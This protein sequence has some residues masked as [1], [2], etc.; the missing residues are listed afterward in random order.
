MSI[1]INETNVEKINPIAYRQSSEEII[2]TPLIQSNVKKI[3]NTVNNILAQI[4]PLFLFL[5][6]MI[7]VD[8]AAGGITTIAFAGI[9]DSDIAGSIG[10]IMLV[11][12]FI[13][14]GPVNLAFSC[15]MCIPYLVALRRNNSRE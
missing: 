11:A 12:G 13:I 8:I 15:I 3:K 7:G 2:T 10:L 5:N 4:Y 14:F 9:F 1:T 6:A